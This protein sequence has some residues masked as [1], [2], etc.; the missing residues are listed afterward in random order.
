[1]IVSLRTTNIFNVLN[2]IGPITAIVEVNAGKPAEKAIPDS[3][4]LYLSKVTDNT[5]SATDSCLSWWS[6]IKTAII[7]FNI[8]AWLDNVKNDTDILYDIVDVI[9]EQ[10]VDEWQN[11]INTWD[12]VRMRKVTEWSPAP[13]AYNVKNRALLVKQYLFTYYAK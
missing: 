2:T 10:I 7:T 11:K 5:T 8:V 9:N 4:Y 3:S 6:L 13:I 12:G 1:M